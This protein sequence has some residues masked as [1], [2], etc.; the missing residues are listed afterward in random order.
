MNF[1]NEKSP[2]HHQ[3]VHK[4]SSSTFF[5]EFSDYLEAVVLCNERLLIAGD[6]NFHVDIPIDGDGLNFLNILQS[7]CFEQPVVGLT[8]V[9]GCSLYLIITRQSNNIID[10]ISKVDRF[11]LITQQSF[12]VFVLTSHHFLPKT[13][14]LDDLNQLI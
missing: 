14:V 2:F 10:N 11:L 12:V 13:L 6:F 7:F 8:H 1:L 9:Y 3:A 4:V 5:T